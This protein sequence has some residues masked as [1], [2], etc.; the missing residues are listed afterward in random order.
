MS[1]AR[2]ASQN[3]HPFLKYGKGGLQKASPLG[4]G[5]PLRDGGE[6]A[7]KERLRCGDQQAGNAP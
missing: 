1:E 3:P 4:S 5:N 6:T 2:V 7:G